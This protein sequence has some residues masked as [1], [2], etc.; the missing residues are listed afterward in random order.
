MFPGSTGDQPTTTAADTSGA[1]DTGGSGGGS[2]TNDQSGDTSAGTGAD[3]ADAGVVLTSNGQPSSAATPTGAQ[4]S[5]ANAA[6]PADLSQMKLKLLSPQDTAKCNAYLDAHFDALLNPGATGT[7]AGDYS[8]ALD[9][10]A[11]QLSDVVNALLP[12]TLFGSSSDP[13][14]GSSRTETASELF[15]LVSAR[16][17]SIVANKISQAGSGGNQPS[18][19]RVLHL[20]ANLLAPPKLDDAAG[21]DS[22]RGAFDKWQ[23]ANTLP[24]PDPAPPL[25]DWFWKPKYL[26]PP[27]PPAEWQQWRSSF[28]AWADGLHLDVKP[29][30]DTI[31]DQLKL[32]DDGDDHP[33]KP[34]KPHEGPPTDDDN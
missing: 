29:I 14:L 7:K 34:R 8:P 30:T 23:Q 27:P 11:V 22:W 5:A 17:D 26:K 21:W 28:K 2:S 15:D 25:P 10:N 33:L 16:Y 1:A 9:G 12:L 4:P 3:N 6:A 18:G 19:P 13:S 31:K 20:P 24:P 32:P